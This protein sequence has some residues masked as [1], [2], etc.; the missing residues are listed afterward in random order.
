MP[1]IYYLVY[2]FIGVIM[3]KPTIRQ[4]PFY[5][6]NAME[7]VD[8]AYCEAGRTIQFPRVKKLDSVV[9]PLLIAST[10]KKGDAA[11]RKQAL[12]ANEGINDLYRV[13]LLKLQSIQQRVDGMLKSDPLLC[14]A[15]P[16]KSQAMVCNIK[17]RSPVAWNA[18]RLVLQYDK[19]MWGILELR[20]SGYFT[21]PK[22][23][24][25][26]MKEAG[27]PVKTLLQLTNNICKQFNE[28]VHSNDAINLESL[29]DSKEVA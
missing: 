14:D 10:S 28:S 22:I 23:C 3:T 1:C 20:N 12:V 26:L 2:Y 27:S 13:A 29:P 24:H 4:L 9:M 7:M 17:L 15:E 25:D 6:R 16:D 11:L 5:S 8:I 21:S 18:V 19:V